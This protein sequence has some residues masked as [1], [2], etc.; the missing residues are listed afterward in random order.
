[1][2]FEEIIKKVEK[3]ANEEAKNLDIKISESA[4]ITIIDDLKEHEDK[5]T[6]KTFTKTAVK[7]PPSTYDIEEST[8][9]L[10]AEASALAV[11]DAR[12]E[13]LPDDIKKA[14]KVIC[15]TYWPFC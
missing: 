1:M 12:E 7:K 6:V 3:I 11:E 9:K 2:K 10:I 15:P 5:I 8:K 14:R 4:I 13:I